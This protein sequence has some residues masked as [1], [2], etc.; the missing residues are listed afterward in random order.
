MLVLIDGLS[1]DLGPGECWKTD[2]GAVVIRAAAVFRMADLTGRR[3]PVPELLYV[4]TWGDRPTV[5]FRCVGTTKNGR[6]V[7]EIGESNPDSLGTEI[8]RNFPFVMAEQRAKVRFA[9]NDLDLKGLVLADIEGPDLT[10]GRYTADMEG[11]TIEAGKPQTPRN[12]RPEN[13]R[14]QPAAAAQK[15][16]KTAPAPAGGPAGHDQCA[17]GSA[18][19]SGAEPAAHTP[20]GGPW[21]EPEAPPP[22]PRQSTRRAPEPA[23]AKRPEPV[24][25]DRTE[26]DPGIDDVEVW[27]GRFKGRTLRELARTD[28]GR[29]WIVEYLCGP[30]YEGRTGKGREI[31][32]AAQRLVA[33]WSS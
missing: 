10:A 12:A 30:K 6:E 26:A 28:E 1:I 21:P 33:G 20:P 24:P 3:V 16:P 22:E 5:V 17:G 18:E 13:G 32:T 29:A 7:S 19:R 9:L 27:F 11:L 8:A 31:K 23:N 25:D 4:G 15:P 14:P 2:D